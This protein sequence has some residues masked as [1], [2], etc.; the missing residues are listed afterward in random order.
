MYIFVKKSSIWRHLEK[1]LIQWNSAEH[2]EVPCIFIKAFYFTVLKIVIIWFMN[3]LIGLESK[4][5]TAFRPNMTWAVATNIYTVLHA[6]ISWR[7]PSIARPVIADSNVS[8]K[9]SVGLII[10]I[11]NMSITNEFGESVVLNLIPN[12]CIE[13]IDIGTILEDVKV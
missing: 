5:R 4:L 8:N 9:T 1:T 10:R 13:S 6:M 7:P 2:I 12:V 11:M 3:S